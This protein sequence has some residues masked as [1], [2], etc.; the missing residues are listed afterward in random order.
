MTTE[1][2]EALEHFAKDLRTPEEEG[3]DDI[4]DEFMTGLEEAFTSSDSQGNGRLNR[5][6]L[7]AF[8]EQMNEKGVNNGLKGRDVTEAWMDI[9]WPVFNGFDEGTEGVSKH[10]LIETMFDIESAIRPK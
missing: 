8:F 4:R 3:G 1:E 2:Q 6:G 7:K 10:D 9:A 5:A